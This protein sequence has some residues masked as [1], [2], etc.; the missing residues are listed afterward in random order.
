MLKKLVTVGIVVGAVA[1]VGCGKKFNCEN[2]AKKNKECADEIV[3][4]MM[5]DMGD[6]VPEKMKEKLKKK[7]K[8]QFA[9]DKFKK[10]CEKNWDSDKD[11][12]KKMKKKLEKCFKKDGCKEYAKCLK[13]SMGG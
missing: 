7:M 1:L 6:K 3:K 9:G 2:I 4:V 12:D 5:A 13:E 8:E 11:R 10:E